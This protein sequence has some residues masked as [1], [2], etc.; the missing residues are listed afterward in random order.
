LSASSPAKRKRKTAPTAIGMTGKVSMVKKSDV[1]VIKT[2]FGK[3]VN[4]A[5]NYAYDW[6]EY[7]DGP[8]LIAAKDEMTIDEQVKQRNADRANAARQ[9][10]YTACLTA[11][12][13]VKP[14]AENDE[15]QRLK[16]MVKTLLT[17]KNKDG[18]QLYTE[19]Q[20][21]QIAATTLQ[22]AWAE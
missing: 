19:E 20:A 16:D 15:Q 3:T 17:G 18:E 14:T 4:P 13:I 7:Q 2:A 1:G 5:L 11:A 8:E 9:K 10:A 21:K 22:L 12:G 6:S